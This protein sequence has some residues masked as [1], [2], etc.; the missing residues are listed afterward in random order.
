[1]KRYRFLALGVVIGVYGIWIYTGPLQTLHVRY[2]DSGLTWGTLVFGLMI[3][4][5]VYF[6]FNLI[7]LR[8]KKDKE[9]DEAEGPG[10]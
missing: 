1:M 10:L 3:P 8:R 9:N 4:Y 2:G 6:I 5:G 7:Q